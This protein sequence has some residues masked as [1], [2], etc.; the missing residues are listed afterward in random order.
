MK[1]KNNLNFSI[2]NN[3]II[4]GGRITKFSLIMLTVI[5]IVLIG[6]VLLPLLFFSTIL[7]T[8]LIFGIL[9]LLNLASAL[10]WNFLE[11][12]VYQMFNNFVN[13]KLDYQFQKS[14]NL[15]ENKLIY[16]TNKT[17]AFVY[18][19]KLI[20]KSFLEIYPNSIQEKN[21]DNL[22]NDFLIL[23]QEENIKFYSINSAFEVQSNLE[24]F[25]KLI[26]KNIDFN[27]STKQILENNE[28]KLLLQQFACFISLDDENTKHNIN[29][30]EFSKTYLLDTKLELTNNIIQSYIQNFDLELNTFRLS[31]SN[32]VLRELNNS[33]IK[34]IKS[35]I[36]LLKQNWDFEFKSKYVKIKDKEE[37]KYTKYVKISELNYI[38]NPFYLF[39]LFNNYWNFEVNLTY[40]SLNPKDESRVVDFIKE[41]NN[42]ASYFWKFKKKKSNNY[43]KKELIHEVLNE[44][45]EEIEI[46]NIPSKSV[47]IIIK[48]TANDLAELTKLTKEF[49]LYLRKQK[50]KFKNLTFLQKRA[51]LDFHLGIENKLRKNGKEKKYFLFKRKFNNVNAF[52]LWL[53]SET[54][55]YSLPFKPIVD[56]EPSGWIF[57]QDNNYNPIAI[58]F[59]LD[60]PNHHIAIFGKT[61]SGKTTATEYLLHQKLIKINNK[62]PLIFI[63]DP[64]G[65]YKNFV[66]EYQG[67]TFN[68]AQGFLNPFKRNS[69]EE[70]IEDKNFVKG[71]LFSLLAP[72]NFKIHVLIPD[73]L[74]LIFY[75]KEWKENKF[76]FDTLSNTVQKNNEMKKELGEEQY[77]A[78]V[79]FIK[80]YSSKGIQSHLFNQ[81]FSIDFFKKIISF[82]LSEL[83]NLG[84]SNETNTIIFCILNK[85]TNLIKL[86]H[87]KF[88]EQHKYDITILVDEFH[89]LVNA[90]DN[91]IIK[92]FD[93]LYAISRSFG[94]GIITISQNLEI[95]NNPKIAHHTK[96]IFSNTAYL[97]AFSQQKI[98]FDSLIQLLPETIEIDEFEKEQLLLDK[99]HQS[100]V[101]YNGQKKFIKWNLGF[102]YDE[103][104]DDDVDGL[105]KIRQDEFNHLNKTIN[106]YIN[107]KKLQGEK[108]E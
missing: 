47:S 56:I 61:G 75:S 19:D 12:S 100:L 34:A 90:E 18:E 30:V 57:G 48:I 27:Q 24:Q 81:D 51:F 26:N 67:Q 29:V 32:L 96:S 108:N 22:I 6:I 95:L 107:L 70:T 4:F 11:T 15:I 8:I 88:K 76:N 7:I 59:N 46:Q 64:K 13:Y 87:P 63:L 106:E 23:L 92:Q 74:E 41:T 97:I 69:I 77:F 72:L 2:E 1:T 53:T 42:T 83:I 28:N 52:T 43:I 40:I 89:L 101:F 16:E 25:Y 84:Q 93:A 17:F 9:S 73:L 55:A 99:K 5:E 38:L 102:F 82:N 65:E 36:L 21:I 71:F 105:K 35:K 94:V 91:T 58:D 104:R 44:T 86:N 49:R 103:K 14:K 60:R 39:N 78:L 62:Q 68:I 50:I 66:Q 3:G 45:I 37:T 85:L 98:Q 20:I 80:Q 33:Y 31:L 10:N 54:C 79:K